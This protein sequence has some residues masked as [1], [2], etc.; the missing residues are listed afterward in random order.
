[1]RRTEALPSELVVRPVLRRFSKIPRGRA[2][3]YHRD[4]VEK[5]R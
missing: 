1:V 4:V 3:S 2:R 5:D